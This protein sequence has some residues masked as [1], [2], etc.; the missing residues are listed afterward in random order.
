MAVVKIMEKEM[1]KVCVIA[2]V[3]ALSG[4]G[5]GDH[6]R[7]VQNPKGADSSH[8]VAQAVENG[9][10]SIDRAWSPADYVAFDAYLAK[11]PAHSYPRVNSSRSSSIFMKVIDS[12]EQPLL[13]K[14][15]IHLNGR[16]ELGLQMQ[17]A[18]NNT[19]KRYY[20]AHNEG[21]D[22]STEIAHL[23][24]LALSI[25]SQMLDLVNEFIPTIDP[26]DGKYEVRMEG[27]KRMKDG[28]AL[29]L[30][31]AVLSMKETNVYSDEERRIIA[32]CLVAEAPAIL[33]HLDQSVRREFDVKIKELQSSE[34]DPKNKQLLATLSDSIARGDSRKPSRG[35]VQ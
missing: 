3:V 20:W 4:C 9:A 34:T 24:G 10:P 32:Q 14:H 23:Q 25:T 18:S 29:Q 21:T 15:D 7:K 19:L 13:A 5:R 16:M 1:L 35:D 2:L 8:T 22:Y 30:D 6:D 27:L 31:G 33:D 12:V 28:I 26:D 17:Q 11:L